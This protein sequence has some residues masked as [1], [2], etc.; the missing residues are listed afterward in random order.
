MK[1][2]L[3]I[4]FFLS[5]NL[6]PLHS[7]ENKNVEF[8]VLPGNSHSISN[9]LSA[10]RDT[11]CMG[12][13]VLPRVA[14]TFGSDFA[15]F[16]IMFKDFE[17]RAGM[18]GMLE[19]E[20]LTKQPW[21]F[22]TV[23]EGPYLWRGILGYSTVFSLHRL[24]DKM[25]G[26]GGGF[27]I[28]LLFR[29]ESEHYTAPFEIEGSIIEVLPPNIG[30]CIITDIGIRIPVKRLEL[31]FR[32]QNKF[33]FPSSEYSFGPG[34]DIILRFKILRYMHLFSS[35][36]S[37]YLFRK[38]RNGRENYYLGNITGIVFPGKI[39]ELQ[40]FSIFSTGYGKGLLSYIKENSIG[41]G[42]RVSVINV[43]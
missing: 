5:I 37:E 32:L 43:K 33:F 25:F 14:T 31:D 13:K 7:R 41:W 12:Y 9:T 17:L 39:A 26:I 42:I 2:R 8:T 18:F 35:I 1:Y 22:L 4:F 29:H 36:F 24:A 19:L 34:I 20:T 38:D 6:F 27:E 28:G 23:P 11:A 30:D 16:G 3:I 40:I 10:S 21:N 15:F